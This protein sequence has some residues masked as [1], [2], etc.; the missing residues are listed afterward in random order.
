MGLRLRPCPILYVLG[1]VRE[2]ENSAYPLN[3]SEVLGHGFHGDFGRVA[4]E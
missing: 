4:F 1:F 2:I 3:E